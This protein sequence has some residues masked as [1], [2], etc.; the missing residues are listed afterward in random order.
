MALISQGQLVNLD[1]RGSHD[2]RPVNVG[3][4]MSLWGGR[5]KSYAELW[6]CQPA[7]RTVVD[8][9]ARN[10]SQIGLHAFDRL[11]DGDRVR[12]RND[13]PLGAWVEQP[14]PDMTALSWLNRLV[15][16][17]A[18]FDRFLAVKFTDRFGRLWALPVPVDMWV[19]M[20]SD[21]TGASH[22]KV[23]QAEVP[24][25][26]VIAIFGYS[27]GSLAKGE[28]PIEAL[29]Q[30]LAGDDAAEQARQGF[31]TGGAQMRGVIERPVGQPISDE[32][33]KRLQGDWQGRYAG[34][35]SAGRT[36]VLEDGM[37]FRPLD[38]KFTDM[39]YLASR[40]LTRSE[41]AGLFHVP[42]P[43]IG[44]LEHATFSNI[45][46]QHKQLY[47]DTLGPW[48]RQIEQELVRQLV[49][50]HFGPSQYLDFNELERLRGTL[51]EQA[52][53]LSTAT[54]G[55][56]MLRDE[57]RARLNLPLLGGAAAELVTP[58][59]VTAGG[60]ASPQDGKH[61]PIRSLRSKGLRLRTKA[62]IGPLEIEPDQSNV[63]A[64]AGVLTDHAERLAKTVASALGAKSALD[65]LIDRE[66]WDTELADD[67]ETVM[68]AITEIA[69]QEAAD[70]FELSDWSPAVMAAWLK[71][72][73]TASAAALNEDLLELLAEAEASDDIGIEE[74]T[75]AKAGSWPTEVLAGTMALGLANW[76]AADTAGRADSAVKTW[77]VTAGN[78]RPTCAASN[79][80][81]VPIGDVFGNGLRWPGDSTGAADLTAGC[82]CVMEISE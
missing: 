80:E 53:I 46:E 67:L 6:R 75:L 62:S 63:D 25:E 43:L 37:T 17:L 68:D 81:T 78:P 82:T 42:P 15:H 79:G 2:P 54:G 77:I 40:S 27:P 32:A 14:A 57:A 30:L 70:L 20:E 50:P 23:G 34:P 16:D 47:V 35:E 39:E 59:N 44:V 18:I 3:A 48:F 66:R 73:R 31:W 9:L 74:A 26:N 13:T 12:L 19:P 8:F 61:A 21:W 10:I 55:P 72:H 41:V 33:L 28:P 11:D 22:Y 24:A 69:G 76:A 51:E 71:E 5:S 64:L 1:R 56:W 49:R 52:A 58:L 4:G 45:T 65:D 36:P 60:Q 7:L 38:A 29:R